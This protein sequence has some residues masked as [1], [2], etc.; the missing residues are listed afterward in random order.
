MP[1][2]GPSQAEHL[3]RA[4][5]FLYLD[6]YRHLS[7]LQTCPASLSTFDILKLIRKLKSKNILEHIIISLF[8]V[9]SVKVILQ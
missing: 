3:S 4:D 7:H 2:P 9:F 6:L 8:S 5:L 1:G